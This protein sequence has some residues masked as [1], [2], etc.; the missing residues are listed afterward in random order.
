[1]NPLGLVQGLLQLLYL[2][3]KGENMININENDNTESTNMG[4]NGPMSVGKLKEY[5]KQAYR[6]LIDVVTKYQDEFTPYL[7]ALAKGL[8]SG[9][10]ALEKEDSSPAEKYVAQFFREA[11][12]GLHEASQKLESKD[13][14]A[15]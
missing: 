8:Q 10:E 14:G 11:S 3:H 7:N 6:P 15:L 5:G 1:V 12:N 2:G 9:C 13:M 4:S